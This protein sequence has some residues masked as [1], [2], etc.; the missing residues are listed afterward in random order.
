VKNMAR[1]QMVEDDEIENVGIMSGFMDD[2]EGLMEEIAQQELSGEGDDA[3]MARILDRRPDSPEILMNNLRGDYRSVDARREELADMVGYNAAQQTPDEVLAMLQPVLAQQGIAA[4]PTGAADVGALPMDAMTGM[5]PGGQPPMDPAMMGG[6]PPMDPAMMG[7]PPMDPAMMGG[8]PPQGIESLPMGD[9]AMPPVQMA[10][11]GIVQRFNQGGEAASATRSTSPLE[12]FL[13]RR[14]QASIDAMSRA[15]ELAPAYQELLGT[16]DKASVRAQ[17]LFDIAQTALGYAANVG[18]D[19]QSL[20]GSQAARLAGA[21]RALPG[22]I[23]ARAAQVRDDEARARMAAL[24]QAQSEE[25]SIQASNAALGKEQRDILLK[26]A[27]RGDP[28]AAFQTIDQQ[29]RA[30]GIVPSAEGGDGRYERAMASSAGAGDGDSTTAFRTLHERAVAGGLSPGSA[31]YQRFMIEGAPQV[32]LSLTVGPDGSIQVSQGAGVGSAMPSSGTGGIGGI[33]T[34][35]PGMAMI[36]QDDGSIELV[37]IPGSPA[38]QA[39]EEDERKRLGRQVQIARAGGTVIQDL[40]RALDLIPDLGA[41]SRNEGILGGI[42][43]ATSKKIPGSLEYQITEFTES[44][45]SNVGLD[46]LQAMRDNSPTGGALGQ[47]PIQQQKR[48]EQVLG[49]LNVNQRPTQLEANIKRVINIYTDIIHGSAEER[50]AA[51]EAGRMTPEES[52]EIDSLYFDLPFDA[53]GRPT[54]RA[55]PTAGPSPAR[56][57]SYDAQG[58]P[59]P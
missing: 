22:Q 57:I 48:L 39:A 53:R 4:L 32:G 2:I 18:P 1:K 59:I 36:Q 34:I 46:T 21:T 50:A 3:D 19:G 52:A 44:A 10:R 7:Q 33:G 6:M 15:R 45:L 11:G 43:R 25:S 30:A 31:E 14:P 49:S 56:R 58:N 54:N 51:V 47:V 35:P 37:M 24:Q 26:M 38:A 13:S 12:E 40:Q 41:L 42:S 9:A 29:L 27:E 16:G 5:P 28:T 55:Q 8:M 17:M 23:G 20:R